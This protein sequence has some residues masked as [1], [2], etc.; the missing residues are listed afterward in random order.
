M[1]NSRQYVVTLFAALAAFVLPAIASADSDELH[2]GFYYPGPIGAWVLEVEFP[3]VDGAPPPPPPFRE[4]LTFHAL[5]TLSESNTLLNENSYNPALGQ[6]CGFTGPGGSL[7]LNCNGSE[8]TGSW[9]RT[10]RNTLSFIAVKF[11]FDGLTNTHVG[12]LRVRGTLKFRGNRIAQDS[13]DSLT[14]IL[15]GTDYDT[16]IAIPLGGANATGVR[17]R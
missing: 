17:I 6:G 12:F 9:R 8:G 11:V 14:E 13:S 2:R 16:A 3:A 15:I 1:I 7:E 4:T 5:G 10:D